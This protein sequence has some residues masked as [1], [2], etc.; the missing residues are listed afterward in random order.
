MVIAGMPCYTNG[1]QHTRGGGGEWFSD[2]SKVTAQICYYSVDTA[3]V[4]VTCGE[5]QVIA[6]VSGP[7]VH[8]VL[9]SQEHFLLLQW[10]R[11]RI[12]L[13]VTTSLLWIMLNA[14]RTH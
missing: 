14:R 1:K 10:R 3:G 11:S 5:L 4:V 2:N 12:R 6:R 9:N 8:I 7:N 13:F